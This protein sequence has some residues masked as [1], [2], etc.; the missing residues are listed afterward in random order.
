MKKRSY[1]VWIL[2][3]GGIMNRRY[4]ECKDWIN[5]DEWRVYFD[6]GFTP[7]EAVNEAHRTV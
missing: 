7:E 1:V 3:V 2:E 6:D 4:P 5:A